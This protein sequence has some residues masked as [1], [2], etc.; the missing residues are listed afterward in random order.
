MSNNNARK[1]SKSVTF[2]DDTKFNN[3]KRNSSGEDKVIYKKPKQFAISYMDDKIY[4]NHIKLSK[5]I[6]LQDSCIIEIRVDNI[7]YHKKVF[8][9]SSLDNWTSYSDHYARHSYTSKCRKYDFF[10]AIIPIIAKYPV[11]FALCYKVCNREYWNNNHTKNF[12]IME[13]CAT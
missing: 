3:I 5:T 4:M 12:S 10:R 8:I 6:P 1:R 9:R 7:D 2:D 11:R 13:F